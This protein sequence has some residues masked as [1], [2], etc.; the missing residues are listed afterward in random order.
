V[1]QEYAEH[2]RRYGDVSRLPTPVFFNGLRVGEETSVHIDQGKTLVIRLLSIA[3][4]DEEGMVR[5]SF[6]LNGQPRDVKV[7]R[8]GAAV[9]AAHPKAEAGNASQVGAPMPGTV[10]TVSV[11]AGQKVQAGDPLVS[12][13]AMKMETMLRAEADGVIE[14]VHVRPG[15]AV[16]AKDLLVTLQ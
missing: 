10:V 11:K 4:H 6:E 1:F 3:E 8:A 15:S 13:E 12:I 9:A 2:R 16:Q 7:A 14:H 5:L